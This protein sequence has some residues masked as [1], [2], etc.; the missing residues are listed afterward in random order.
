MVT[1]LESNMN[2]KFEK[3]YY[4]NIEE[5]SFYNKIT[6][7]YS[8]K[9]CDFITLIDSDLIFIEAKSSS[10]KD[11]EELESY[12]KDIYQKF[13]DSIMIYTSVLFDRKNT[14]S[15]NIIES[16]K[17]QSYLKKDIKLVLVINGMCKKA[18]IDIKNVLEK[19]LR[20]LKYLFS[21]SEL[22][23]INDVQA[24]SKGIVL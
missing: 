20:K 18:L 15:S 7:K 21:I 6:S 11:K 19:S 16:M 24:K 5:D 12:M 9:V 3:E 10:P 13:L 2:F 1:K 14:S 4:Y 23:V 22:I 8:A 17:K